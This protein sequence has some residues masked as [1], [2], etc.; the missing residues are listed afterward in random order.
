MR[1]LFL[2]VRARV[3]PL[4]AHHHRSQLLVVLSAAQ[5]SSWCETRFFFAQSRCSSSS[6]LFFA[7]SSPTSCSAPCFNTSNMQGGFS[8]ATR[9][10]PHVPSV[11]VNATF[12]MWRWSHPGCD[13]QPA[14]VHYLTAPLGCYVH[15]GLGGGYSK[16]SC[17]N[18]VLLWGD[19]EEPMCRY[20]KYDPA[21][22]KTGACVDDASPAT[23]SYIA[24]CLVA[25]DLPFR[26]RV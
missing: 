12:Q 4:P 6:Y 23:G 17:V 3:L 5:N 7:S 21:M 1:A 14:T 26:A 10:L 11:P 2:L 9:P 20:P 18:G 8:Q 24:K 15:T 25:D 16:W 13:G 22:F 19:Y